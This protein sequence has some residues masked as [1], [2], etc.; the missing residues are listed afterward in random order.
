[1]PYTLTV[2]VRVTD[3]DLPVYVRRDTP[4]AQ[5][6]WVAEHWSNLVHVKTPALNVE[7]VR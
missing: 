5:K 7:P 3:G 1:M 6:L 4:E 2:K